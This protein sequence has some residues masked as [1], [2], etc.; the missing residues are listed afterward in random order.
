MK[1]N[2]STEP[3]DITAEAL[4]TDIDVELSYPLFTEIWEKVPSDW[5]DEY[6][7]KLPRKETSATVLTREESCFCQCLGK[8]SKE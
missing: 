6:L 4:K 3:D 8:Y 2:K 5:R 7:I 1:N